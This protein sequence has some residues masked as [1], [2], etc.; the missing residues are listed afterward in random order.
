MNFLNSITMM[1]RYNGFT[2]SD[3]DASCDLALNTAGQPGT[4]FP[5]AP[6]A[7]THRSPSRRPCSQPCVGWRIGKA[8]ESHLA[9]CTGRFWSG[10]AS[11]QRAGRRKTAAWVSSGPASTEVHVSQ[12][13]GRNWFSLTHHLVQAC[14]GIFARASS[15]VPFAGPRETRAPGPQEKTYFDDSILTVFTFSGA[16]GAAQRQ[17]VSNSHAGAGGGHSAGSRR[18]R[19]ARHR[20]DR[21]RQDPQLPHPDHGDA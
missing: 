4:N 11:R 1:L 7:C 13:Q 12:S 18:P 20:A 3:L 6:T 5:Q 16:H 8:P 14:A 10:V 2:L 17:Q 9:R 15:Q 21:N 19:R